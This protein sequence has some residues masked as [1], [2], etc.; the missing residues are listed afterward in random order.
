MVKKKYGFFS[1]LWL[2]VRY[3]PGTAIFIAVFEICLGVVPTL[4]TLAVAGF[5]DSSLKL[6]AHE[7]EYSHVLSYIIAII[8]LIAAV[9]LSK[10]LKELLLAKLELGLRQTFRVEITEKR[11]R[12]KY[13]HIEDAAS[14]D[15]ISRI[16]DKPETRL[17]D[18]YVNFLDFLALVIRIGGLILL[19]VSQVWQIAIIMLVITVPLV[20]ISLRSGR[21]NYITHQETQKYH[22]RQK[23]LGDVLISRE[24]AQERLLFHYGEGFSQMWHRVYEKARKKELITRRN[25]FIRSKMGGMLTTSISIIAS[26][27]LIQPVLAGNISTGTFISFIN[28]IYTLV[29]AVVWSLA[30]YVEIIADNNEY[31]KDYQLFNALEEQS[32]GREDIR[33]A[34][35]FESLEFR[36][37]RFKYPNTDRYVLDGFS[38]KFIRGVSYAL[39]GINGAGK[40]TL[41][42]LMLGLYDNY[43][44]NILLNGKDIRAY[45]AAAVKRVYSVVFQDYARYSLTI[46]ENIMIGTLQGELRAASARTAEITRTVGLH[47][48]L[49]ALPEG[50]KTKLGKIYEDGQDVSGGQWQ[51]IA[52]ARSMMRDGE[53]CILDEPTAALDPISESRLYKEFKNLSIGKTM[54]LISHRLGST[55]I[56][57][58]ILVLSEGKLLEADTHQALIDKQG[59]YAS[60]YNSQRSWYDT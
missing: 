56:A 35:Y 21:E 9:W 25:W 44:G 18:A 48:Q 23:Y 42:N 27:L 58:I 37:I 12:L 54:I 52:L 36:D 33:E 46:E 55:S 3:C 31:M 13:F 2:P 16:A 29:D 60:M 57:D 17:K 14:W 7:T 47:S 59:L 15:L 4:Q 32:Q 30:G 43:T 38:Y 39:T 26:L 19:F 34:I 11:R 40:T 28:S 51:R 6:A 24:A 10:S 22:R 45:S 41:V 49:A 50:I 1:I 20:M 53:V 5:I 8:F